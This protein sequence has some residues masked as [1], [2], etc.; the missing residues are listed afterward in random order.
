MSEPNL[1][2]VV[3]HNL[4]DKMIKQTSQAS[5]GWVVLVLDD[6]TT[7]LASS[8]LRMTDL[9]ERGVSIVERLELARQP[10]PEMAVIYFISPTIASIEKVVADFSNAEKP[11]YNTVH[12]FFNA[13]ADNTVLS[14]FKSC[15]PLLKR[16]RTLKEV[17]LDFHATERA[18][19][20]LNL[21]NA[22][23]TLYSPL[24]TPA[25]LDSLLNEISA[26][27]VTLCATLDE[28]PYVRYKAGQNKMEALAKLFQSK[29][30][31]YVAANASFTY[32]PN[33]STLLFVE[34]AQ[35]QLSPL[36]HEVTYQAMVYDLLDGAGLEGDSINYPAETQSG[37][38]T[39][40]A[41][42]NE[43]DPLWS[44]LR[45]THIA[46][47]TTN[48]G[49]RMASLSSSNA[50]TSLQSKGKSPD[51]SQLAAALRELPEFRDTL[52]KLSQ[53]LYLAGKTLEEYTK[54][55][56]LGVSTLEQSLA[57]GVDESGKKIKLPKVQKDMEDL[58]RD[59]KIPNS[60]K[61]R[62]LAI[63][64]ITQDSTKEAERKKL[65]SIAQLPAITDKALQ[66]M[67]Y[68]GV[69]MQKISVVSNAT[70]HNLTSE[71]IKDAAKKATTSEYATARYE[72]K[73]KGWMDKILKKNLDTTEFP[74]VITPPPGTNSPTN[75]KEPTSLR[76]KIT[77]KIGG[78]SGSDSSS[79]KDMFTGDKLIVFVVGGATY[80][81]L[82]SV[83]ELRQSEKREVVLG[84]TSFLRPKA[85][86]ES[87]I[88]LEES[89]PL[90]IKPTQPEMALIH[91]SDIKLDEAKLN[92]SKSISS[93]S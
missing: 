87:L 30:N 39:K 84:S 14:K 69:F 91:P 1:R 51:V 88:V 34:R 54:Q 61:A 22:L 27:L 93:Q 28:Y 19:F 73:L 90:T 49:N 53:H 45:H 77:A 42:L 29:M 72:P 71:E 8:V 6:T 16:L 64:I 38:V 60:D 59:P 82:R 89:T 3:Q 31:E 25:M 13:H 63:F 23:Y 41:L 92:S 85:F 33:R 43:N 48:I 20:S 17:N 79:S 10:F 7:T 86:L 65:F 24:S 50:G 40:Q 44:E 4:L 66:N 32:C 78:K 57:T 62:L 5:H 35:D 15:Q 37:T 18:A 2:A 56:L 75:K 46:E 68:M 26:K 11:M 12:L 80:S 81:E 83:Y 74:Y 67:K 47:V 55:N 70:G 21:Q 36:V 58:L 52:S 76:K 9:T